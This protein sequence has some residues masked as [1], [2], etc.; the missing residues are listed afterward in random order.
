MAFLPGGT[1]VSTR[2]S[3]NSGYF[4]FGSNRLVNVDNIKLDMNWQSA[5][6]YVLNS[7]KIQSL[8]RHTEKITITGQ[9]TTFSTELDS[10]I[11]GS[12]S[13][14]AT[15]TYTPLDGQ[16][17]LQNPT[18]TVYDASNKEYQFQIQGALFTKLSLNTTKEAFAIYDFSIEAEDL[19]FLATV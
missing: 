15:I 3:F 12:S 16:P 13:T 8:A 10:I 5:A 14:G 7:I 6:L 19:L 18:L 1:P 11:Y 2:V 9:I 17:T 4:D